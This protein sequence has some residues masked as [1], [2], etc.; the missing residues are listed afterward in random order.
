MELRDLNL[1]S[2]NI[3]RCVCLSKNSR[4]RQDIIDDYIRVH[5]QKVHQQ[6]IFM[7]YQIKS[8]SF[9]NTC[10]RLPPLDKLLMDKTY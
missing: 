4:N 5:H 1:E 8:E 10:F 7:V 9:C 2:I 3:S 6:L